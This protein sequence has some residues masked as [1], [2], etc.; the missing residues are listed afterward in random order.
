M[1]VVKKV[2]YA[3]GGRRLIGLMRVLERLN[4]RIGTQGRKKALTL[5]GFS[6]PW[7]CCCGLQVWSLIPKGSGARGAQLLAGTQPA[8]Q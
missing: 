8:S 5:S 2:K 7:D 1:H 4:L 3:R 6:S